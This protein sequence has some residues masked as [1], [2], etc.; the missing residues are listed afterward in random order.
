MKVKLIQANTFNEGM[1][2]GSFKTSESFAV[3]KEGKIMLLR[4]NDRIND[5][6]IDEPIDFSYQKLD[7][8]IIFKSHK[9]SKYVLKI[10]RLSIEHYKYFADLNWFQYLKIQ[11]QKDNLFIKKSNIHR[12]IYPIIISVSVITIPYLFQFFINLL[13][14]LL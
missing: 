8:E 1:Y 9:F 2:Y 13:K 5:L 14:K 10:Q 11:Y 6:L 12:L 7:N 3:I 4:L